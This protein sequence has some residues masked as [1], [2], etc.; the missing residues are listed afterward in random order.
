MGTTWGRLILTDH[1]DAI[2]TRD[3]STRYQFVKWHLS[4]CV[5]NWRN[6]IEICES[7]L[8]SQ[9]DTVHQS[10]IRSHSLTRSRSLIHGISGTGV[11]G[12]GTGTGIAEYGISATGDSGTGTGTGIAEYGI[13]GTGTGIAECG[14][15]GTGIGIAEYGISGTGIAECFF[16]ISATGDSGAGLQR[17][18]RGMG[19]Q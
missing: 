3:S 10:R 2:Y 6:P 5:S 15:S 11:S 7:S 13:S 18:R 8:Q 17:G 14:I 1:Y 4:G 12:T 9:F 16:C 19:D